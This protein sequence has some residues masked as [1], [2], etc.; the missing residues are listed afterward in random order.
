MSSGVAGLRPDPL[1]GAR[2]WLSGRFRRLL[3]LLPRDLADAYPSTPVV[4][5][6]GQVRNSTTSVLPSAR[7]MRLRTLRECPS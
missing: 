2:G 1:A 5:L 4:E 6:S 7:A 3:P